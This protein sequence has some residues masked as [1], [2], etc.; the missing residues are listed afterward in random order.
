MNIEHLEENIKKSV[1]AVLSNDTGNIVGTGF[2]ASENLVVTCSHVLVAANA[3]DGDVVKI[4]FDGQSDI[5]DALVVPEYWRDVKNGDVAILRLDRV[6]ENISPLRLGEPNGS[7]GNHFYAYGYATVTD[8]QGIGARG[9]VTDILTNQQVQLTSQELAPGMSGCPVFDVKRHEVIGVVKKGKDKVEAGKDSRNLLTSFATSISVF[10][11]I[12]PDIKVNKFTDG[13]L[14]DTTYR[15]ALPPRQDYDFVGRE[16]VKKEIKSRLENPKTPNIV[17]ITGM[18]GS[19][20]TALAVQASAEMGEFFGNVFWGDLTESNGDPAP[21]LRGWAGLCNVPFSDNATVAEIELQMRGILKK[22]QDETWP[23]LVVIDAL[24]ENWLEAGLSLRNA[25]PEN[26]KILI[27]SRERV[28]AQALKASMISLE[29]YPLSNSDAYKILKSRSEKTIDRASAIFI[30]E[31][32]ENMPLALELASQVAREAESS[33]YLLQKLKDEKKRLDS[34]AFDNPKYRKRK[35]Q[36]VR[37]TFDISYDIL[38]EKTAIVFRC[39]GAFAPVA[40][41]SRQLEMVLANL[42]HN[43]IDA[44]EELQRLRRYSLLREVEGT[45]RMHA[46]LHEYAIQKLELNPAD[47]DKSRIAHLI[48]SHDFAQTFHGIDFSNRSNL[49]IQ[50]FEMYYPQFLHALESYGK[51]D[52]KSEDFG[53]LPVIQLIELMDVYWGKYSRFDE[54]EKWLAVAYKR[55]GILGLTTKQADLAR[56]LGRVLSR[57]RKLDKALEWMAV[58]E[59]HLPEKDNETTT[60]IRALM[61]IHKAAALFFK[62][63]NASAKENVLLGLELADKDRYPAIFAEGM[64]VLGVS[65]I[66]LG[67][68]SSA[69]DALRDSLA[70]WKQLGDQYQI[71]RVGDNI[72]SNLY[73]MGRI[74]ELRDAE[75][76][77]MLY[78]KQFPDTVEWPMALTN[79][80]LVHY[81]DGEHDESIKLHR[82]AM[83]IGDELMA[84]RI[85]ALTRLNISWPYIALGNY[86]EAEK[87]LND[88]LTIQADYN[89]EEYKIDTIRCLAEV[90][91]ARTNFDK[92][93]EIVIEAVKLAREDDDPLEIGAALRVLGEAHLR[94]GNLEAAQECL[95]ESFAVLQEN[96]YRY[97][98]YLTL[99]LCA[100]LYKDLGNLQ[101]AKQAGDNAQDLAKEMGLRVS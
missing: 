61:Y 27:T 88:S 16:T 95:D 46:L 67:E 54:Q 43:N 77:S 56:R 101:R 100:Q 83:Q 26:I 14:W 59:S 75:D 51:L 44:D 30:A 68:L 64:N 69:F 49:G 62:G 6:P 47:A 89:A 80:G 13:Y 33:E 58:C 42:G 82:Q 11:G 84:Q 1:V 91:I 20:K 98:S 76:K 72:R 85:R 12:C 50:E 78:W 3:F 99:Q 31:I 18:G 45:Y 55:A 21:I 37:I 60:P 38:P 41:S 24:Q 74:A 97:E 92:A 8:V 10:A 29:K 86:E 17:C 22:R 15:L 73:Y 36:S 40:I 96:E 28:V 63:E 52:S 70:V 57:R 4:R 71:Y 81:V 25:V 34:F 79:R 23:I 19:G 65:S 5:F 93:I 53:L 66:E 32:C 94:K 2:L 90:E 35:G 9:T 39:L 48:C 7:A 87:H